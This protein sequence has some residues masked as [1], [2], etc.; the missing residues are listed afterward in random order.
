MAVLV[1]VVGVVTVAR[2][3]KIMM[4]GLRKRQMAIADT[5]RKSQEFSFVVHSAANSKIGQGYLSFSQ[6]AGSD[7]IE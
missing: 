4:L 1:R 5:G 7:S 3:M 2:M 6:L